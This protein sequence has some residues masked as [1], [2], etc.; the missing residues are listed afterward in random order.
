MAKNLNLI[1]EIQN[2]LINIRN[3]YSS[4]PALYPTGVYDAQT[5]KAV[6]E[7]QNMKG[8]P[9][10]GSID[11]LTWNE[12]IRENNEHVKRTQK[13]HKMLVATHDFEEVKIGDE[14]DIVFTIKIILNSFHKKFSNYHELE[15]TNLY[16]TETEETIK[17]FQ[18]RSMLP[19]TGIVDKDT[20][21]TMAAIY[22]SCRF[23]I[24]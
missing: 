14:K 24:C 9:P 21:N 6:Y 17:M 16:N 1:S 2:Y 23:Y 18:E 4:L 12:L 8:L 15:I 22:D 3:I 20:W 13:P 10:T 7:F 11:I 19:V 5:R